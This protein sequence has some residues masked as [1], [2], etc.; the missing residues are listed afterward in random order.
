MKR[1]LG[2]NPTGSL[3]GVNRF[4]V[5]SKMQMV[6]VVCRA[7]EISPTLAGEC[8]GVFHPEFDFPANPF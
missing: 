8:F 6:P 3:G 5:S 2:A 4:Q 1:T 7:L